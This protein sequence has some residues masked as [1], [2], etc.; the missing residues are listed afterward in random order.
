MHSE[1]RQVDDLRLVALPS[2]V[3]CTEIFV[4]FTLTEWSLRSLIDEATRAA[5]E[6][7]N[8]V[9]ED[10]DAQSPGLL[11]VR[12]RLQGEG[13]VI[14][15]EGSHLAR[16]PAEAPTVPDARTG[17]VPRQDGVTHLWCELALPQGL[18]GT[19]LPLPR[20]DTTKSTARQATDEER[21]EMDPQLMQR[22]LSSLG[23]QGSPD[24]VQP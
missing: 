1:T 18:N 19:Q 17:M 12:L 11:S 23:G 20:R 13:M 24:D 16:P 10:S 22:I 21:A 14:E 2:A 3:N 4:R 9:I 15:L 8:A 6:L 7:V 5:T